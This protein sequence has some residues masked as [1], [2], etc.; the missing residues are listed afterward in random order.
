MF[1]KPSPTKEG[2]AMIDKRKQYINCLLFECKKNKYI[3]RANLKKLIS[4]MRANNVI[5]SKERIEELLHF[6]R[7]YMDEKHKLQTKEKL[8]E[9]KKYAK[10]LFNTC[11]SQQIHLL[12]IEDQN[13]PTLLKQ[14][15]NAPFFIFLKGSMQEF[16]ESL[17]YLAVIGSRKM[18]SYGRRVVSEVLKPS[19]Q[20][21]IVIVSGLA[22]GCDTAA[23][24]VAI[25]NKLY[26]IAC[27]AHGHNYCYPPEH[28]N[29]KEEIEKHGCTISEHPPNVK[30]LPQYFAARNRIIS[31]LSQY[32]LVIE[33][34][35]KS[36][37]LLTAEFAATQ[38]RD[39]LCIPG[40]IFYNSSAGCNRLIADGA[41]PIHNSFD[42]CDAMN[43]QYSNNKSTENE[44]KDIIIK[45]LQEEA[46][47]EEE[48]ASRLRISVIDLR[49]VLIPYEAQGYIFRRDGRL[50]LTSS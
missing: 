46:L 36:G 38:G 28:I 2:L 43:L 34:N 26:T 29:I 35:A 15:P 23:H 14:I 6:I 17:H 50:F 31:G 20:K 33:A 9:L 37:T 39:V 44:N 16:P 12:N 11:W 7:T 24:K 1:W 48:L 40:S 19:M 47:S 49:I 5:T 42:L 10:E 27:L 8:L 21:D 30:P 32:L 25:E 22:R 13:Y 18:T 4:K 45:A 41:K 3:N